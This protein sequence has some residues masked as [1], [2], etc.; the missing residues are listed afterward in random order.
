[1]EI[2]QLILEALSLPI[3]ATSYYVSQKLAE[4]YP[5]LALVEGSDCSFNLESY[6]RAHKCTIEQ[7][8]IIHNQV[9]TSWDG[10]SKVVHH[11]VSNAYLK[12]T[13]HRHTLDVLLMSWGTEW[14]TVRYYWILAETK[15]VAENF[16]ADVAEWN[17]QIREEVLVF[18]EGY[19]AKSPELFRAIKSATFDNLVLRGSLKQD[20]QDDL[21]NFF[22]S[23]NTYQ[24]YGILWKRGILLIGSP[25][26]GKTHAVKALINKM[27][28]PCLY[29]KSFKARYDNESENIRK[30][31]DRARTSAPCILVL[32][33]L[34]SLVNAENRS[35]FLNELDG[36]ASNSG[37][38][39]IATTN[40]PE[41]LDPAIV[42]RPSR[43]DR[44][45][46]FELPN[47]QERLAYIKLWNQTLKADM[48][49]GEKAMTQVSELT[50]G[51]SFAYLKELFLSSSIR[52][53]ATMESGGLEKTM[54]EQ[55]A[56][57]REQMSSGTTE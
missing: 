3:N 56:T 57:L 35:F 43:F 55:V 40:H 29:V 23:Q 28:Q 16:F 5:E 47:Q 32:E 50:D 4:L 42:D 10:S 46:H 2:K 13:W 41:R 36:F 45:Y 9:K 18:E 31:F 7:Q 21:G 34:D 12:V 49:L 11:G 38:V 25:G 37:I 51:F 24:E 1:V 52:W 6:A 54:L 22:S 17:E 30:V 48:L 20:I 33:D 19:W 8:E 26:N 14:S 27:Q 39:T 53:I 44:K 15:E